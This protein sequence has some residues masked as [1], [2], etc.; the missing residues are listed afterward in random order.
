M[1][2]EELDST[3]RAIHCV[4]SPT[5]TVLSRHFPTTSPSEL[6]RTLALDST[7]GFSTTSTTGLTLVVR[8]LSVA[9]SGKRPCSDVIVAVSLTEWVSSSAAIIAEESV[10]TSQDTKKNITSIPPARSAC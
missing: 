10:A 6:S 1:T 7:F 4:S 9:I 3:Q 5:S 2:R 8:R